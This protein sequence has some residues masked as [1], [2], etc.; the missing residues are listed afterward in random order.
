M[1][2]LQAGKDV[3]LG[4]GD[5]GSTSVRHDEPRALTLKQFRTL[6][7][8]QWHLA[9]FKHPVHGSRSKRIGEENVTSWGCCGPQCKEAAYI[10]YFPTIYGALDWIY[11]RGIKS[12]PAPGKAEGSETPLV[13]LEP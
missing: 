12:S 6:G 3:G 7:S 8:L 13:D 1:L 9:A 11:H 2:S 5:V 10:E 4:F